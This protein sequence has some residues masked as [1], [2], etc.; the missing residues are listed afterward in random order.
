[1]SDFWCSLIKNTAFFPDR[2][3]DVKTLNLFIK[4]ILIFN[5]NKLRKKLFFPILCNRPLKF[6]RFMIVSHV[7]EANQNAIV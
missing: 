3:N 4:V 2:M 5:I 7:I 1:M 6:Q